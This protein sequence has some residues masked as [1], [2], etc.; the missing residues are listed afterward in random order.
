ME[1]DD[2]QVKMDI[3]KKLVY[4]GEIIAEESNGFM[5]GRG[6]YS[7]NGNIYS[8]CLGLILT[9]DKL[10]NVNTINKNN[11]LDQGDVI[12]GKVVTVENGSWRVNI[13]AKRFGVLNIVNVNL[14]SGEHRKRLEEDFLNMKTFF[15]EGSVLSGE[16]LTHNSDGHISLQTRNLKY[17][18]MSNGLLV[19]VNSK[20]VIKMKSHFFNL[21]N[22]INCIVGMNGFIFIYYAVKVESSYGNF[23]D[24]KNVTPTLEALYLIVLFKNI[25]LELVENSMVINTKNILLFFKYYGTIGSFILSLKH[26]SIIENPNNFKFY[27][28]CL[29]TLKNSL[30]ISKSI[31]KR[32]VN[33]LQ[34]FQ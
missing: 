12:I 34:E 32:I 26:Q 5:P 29:E 15:N 21:C 20:S 25:I 27:T 6:T 13:N 17:G 7:K 16:V 18:K 2:D 11:I 22:N 30:I 19:K 10:I 9:I 14:P 1:I 8:S 24:D 3:I 4:P 28:L 31:S 33:K 23:I